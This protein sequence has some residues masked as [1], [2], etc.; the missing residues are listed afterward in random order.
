MAW[1]WDWGPWWYNGGFVILY[2]RM[3]C[4]KWGPLMKR[5]ENCG[6]FMT[7]WKIFDL[8]HTFSLNGS[9]SNVVPT[10]C[11]WITMVTQNDI[12]AVLRNFVP[13]LVEDN[14]RE[15][16]WRS[17]EFKIWTCLELGYLSI[18]FQYLNLIIW[19]LGGPDGIT[20]WRFYHT[21]MIE[22][23]NERWVRGTTLSWRSCYP[24]GVQVAKGI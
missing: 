24:A 20:F 6:P 17:Y 1:W 16:Q 8:D 11:S 19:L 13:A 12:V 2:L 7:W 4:G 9:L 23:M 21:K 22:M 15:Q 14:N 5:L 18:F 3:L 10:F